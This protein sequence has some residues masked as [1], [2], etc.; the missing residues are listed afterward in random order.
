[1]KTLIVDT[2]NMRVSYNGI[3]ENVMFEQLNLPNP[4]DCSNVYENTITG[5]E[6]ENVILEHFKKEGFTHIKDPESPIEAYE[7]DEHIRKTNDYIAKM[8]QHVKN[9]IAD[10][11]DINWNFC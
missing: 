6:N 7:I 2:V 1:M 3:D 11:K 8:H 5:L 9:L 10:G 4:E